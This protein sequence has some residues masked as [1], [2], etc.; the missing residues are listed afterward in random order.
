MALQNFIALVRDGLHECQ[1]CRAKEIAAYL[2]KRNG[3]QIDVRIVNQIL[4][5]P[6]YDKVEQ[7]SNYEWSFRGTHPAERQARMTES[8]PHGQAC[9]QD[10]LPAKGKDGEVV[11]ARLLRTLQ[12]LRSG[13]PPTEGL[14]HLSVGYGRAISAIEQRLNGED[15]AGRWLMARGN[16]GAG[17]THFLQT[18]RS[19]AHSRGFATCYLCADSGMSALNHPQRFMAGL[20][21]SL[22]IPGRASL[23][24]EPFILDMA[25][26]AEGRKVLL[27]HCRKWSIGRRMP[28]AQAIWRLWTLASIHDGADG[29]D[30][31]HSPWVAGLLADDLSGITIAHRAATADVRQSAYHLLL[32][33]RD[34]L[35]LSGRRGLVIL[36]DEVESIYT[37]L[38]NYRSRAGAMRVLAA[39]CQSRSFEGVLTALAMTPDAHRML[40]R[41]MAGIYFDDCLRSLEPV[42]SLLRNFTDGSPH[43]VDC[44]VIRGAEVGTLLER[45]RRLYLAA[46]RGWSQSP[47]QKSAWA[48]F[49]GKTRAPD[50]PNRLLVRQ[51]IDLLD[52]QRY[53][54]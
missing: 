15:G 32:M 40:V 47:A 36:L 8:E 16:Y 29:A 5:G 42:S 4:Y 49:A 10:L 45:V 3:I 1:P 26:T 34:L 19:L 41:E 52:A 50:L 30:V 22:E 33:A 46:Y 11:R 24:Y 14:E 18:V 13:L 35:I 37:K 9:E 53:G 17:K 25:A 28:F 20:L 7:N 51:A 21:G 23:G 31:R 54:A 48:R 43:L 27:Q 39:L 12:R 44:H 2:R 6:L 38:P